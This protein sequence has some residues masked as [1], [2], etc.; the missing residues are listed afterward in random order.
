MSEKITDFLHDL[1]CGCTKGK[2]VAVCIMEDHPFI[3][4][5][6]AKMDATMAELTAELDVINEK[7][8]NAKSAIAICDRLRK[9]PGPRAQEAAARAER[10]R[11]QNFEWE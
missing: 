2:K 7:Q 5:K 6:V 10:L 3:K 1:L 11:L 8:K 9:M 4:E